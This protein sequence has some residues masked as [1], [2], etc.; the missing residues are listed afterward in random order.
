MEKYIVTLTESERD[1]LMRITRKGASKAQKVINALIL[2]NCDRGAFNPKIKTG[3]AIAAMLQI[4]ERKLDRVKKRFVEEGLEIALGARQG[5]RAYYDRKMDGKLEAQLV[6]LC[7]S[8]PPPGRSQWT[9]RLLA[10]RLVELEYVDSISH[11]TVRRALKKTQL[12][13]GDGSIG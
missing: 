1:E 7:C 4:S 10:D 13:L 9:L 12:S 6:A 5:R 3:E 2:L 11:E 8:A